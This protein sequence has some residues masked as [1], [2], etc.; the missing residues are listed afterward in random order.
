MHFL[1]S[2]SFLVGLLF[3]FPWSFFWGVLSNLDFSF[4]I[5]KIGGKKKPDEIYRISILLNVL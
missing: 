1:D 2:D 5:L 3:L 4:F